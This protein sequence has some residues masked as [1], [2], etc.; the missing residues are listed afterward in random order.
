MK[1]LQHPHFSMRFLKFDFNLGNPYKIKEVLS[2][3]D[4]SLKLHLLL[5]W[6]VFLV[7][8]GIF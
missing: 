5:H 2:N 4:G 8:I 1:M 3:W 6:S 7:L